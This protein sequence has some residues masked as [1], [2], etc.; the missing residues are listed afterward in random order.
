M[1]EKNVKMNEKDSFLNSETPTDA[2][3][4]I[5]KEKT[6]KCFG[7]DTTLTRSQLIT[8]TLITLYF[9]LASAYYALFAPFLPG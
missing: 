5:H 9:F 4:S 3:D 1:E 2:T 6:I 7:K 8:L